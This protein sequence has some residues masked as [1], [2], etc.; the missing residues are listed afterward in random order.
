MN[1]DIIQGKWQQ[2]TAEAKKVWG[3]L[4]DDDFTQAQGN[5]EKLAGLI[6]ERYGRSKEQAQ[7][8]VQEFIAKYGT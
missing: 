7:R 1:Q 4:S 3:K 2:I 6:Q 5:V 8:E